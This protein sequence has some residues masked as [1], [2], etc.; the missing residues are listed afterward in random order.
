LAIFTATA[1]E[2]PIQIQTYGSS[3]R[4]ELSF[5]LI[6][7]QGSDVDIEGRKYQ[8]ITIPGDAN[9]MEAGAPDLP[10]VCRSVIIPDDAR[11]KLRVLD[12]QYHELQGWIAPSKGT[13][14]RTKNPAEVPYTFGPVYRRDAFY[15]AEPACLGEPYI[16]RDHRGIVV[17]LHPFQY[18]PMTQTLRIYTRLD[19]EVSVA[20]PGQ[21]NV[22]TRSDR[23]RK[24]SRAFQGIYANH[25]LN[26]NPQSRYDPLDEEGDLLI[27]CHDPWM[28]YVQPL[29]EYKK[30]IGINAGVVGVS[31]IG[32]DAYVILN[33]LKDVYN[34]TDL[35][36]VLLVGDAEQVPSLHIVIGAE[37]GSSDPYYSLL[38]GYDAYPEIMVGRFS[39]ETAAQVHTQVSRTLAYELAPATGQD[40]FWRGT[41]IG[42]DEGPG[43]DNEMDYEHI[44]NIRTLLLANGYTE[45]DQIYDPGAEALDVK[46]ALDAGRGIVNYCGHGGS[47][48]LGTSG[49]VIN[50]A[51]TLINHD[52]LPFF[53][54][55][56]CATGQF[57][58]NT[59]IAEVLL[60]H[61]H[62]GSHCGA[63]GFYGGSLA[64]Y[65]SEPM[66]AQDEFNFLL[67]DAEYAGLGTL[68]FGGSCSMMDKYGQSGQDMFLTW[69][70]F[71]DPSVRVRGETPSPSGLEMLP[72]EGLMPQ[73]A[74]GGPFD[75]E[76]R[77]YT[78]KNHDTAPMTYE[79]SCSADWVTL[80]KSA[81]TI[82]AG[83]QIE[84]TVSVNGLAETFKRGHYEAAVDI[85]CPSHPEESTKRTA[86]LDV[87]VPQPV[88]VFDMN[89]N[90]GWIM[91]GEWEYGRPSGLGGD[92]N[93]YPDPVSGAT[94]QKVCGVN[95]LGDY[96]VDPGGPFYLIMD[97]P[98]NCN[99]LVDVQL[100]FM[101]WLNSD[102]QPYFFSTVEVSNNNQDWHLV[103]ENGGS[104]VA[105]NAWHEKIYD[106]S[107]LADRQSEVYIR[108]G[109]E[110]G[111]PTYPYSGWNLDDIEIRGV[112]IKTPMKERPCEKGIQ[113]P[114]GAGS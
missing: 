16:L 97:P 1:A 15:P 3:D 107:D 25:F 63:I 6:D 35:A 94:G 44:D 85:V 98:V 53:F 33:F 93:G 105:E 38:E 75:P 108:W 68:C 73:G 17:E 29:V 109:Y 71:A 103:Y 24:P 27:I 76:E 39:A 91:T 60:R 62:G 81:G 2:S 21:I 70:L 57:E 66:E 19:V 47:G 46:E 95:L 69:H 112:R 61:T 110:K 101:R 80:D 58:G 102:F 23:T 54:M 49:F 89:K 34:T 45:I 4:I 37:K 9:M 30:S 96:S 79:V 77:T 51:E 7:W 11:M 22:K 99:D 20:G 28:A 88:Y 113:T 8:R 52:M 87:G 12:A 78:L 31:T 92:E 64:Q 65:W 41:G 111:S 26:H 86:I 74:R 83:G 55:V 114:A 18:N 84:L 43:D 48:G 67:V 100:R 36:F 5:D 14:E 50:H 40:W 106:I 32:N 13:L 42:S 59:C 104:E 90:P 56:A 82:P 10:K 72:Y